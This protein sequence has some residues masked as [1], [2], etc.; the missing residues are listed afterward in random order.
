M[1]N[2]LLEL[3]W[4]TSRGMFIAP[5]QM[6]TGHLFNTVVMIWNNFMPDHMATNKFYRRYQFGE[7][8][9][10]KYLRSILVAMLLE[11]GTRSLDPNQLLILNKMGTFFGEKRWLSANS[12]SWQNHINQ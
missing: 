8:Y 6:K 12:Y 9:T 1:A 11:L 5:K 4:R 10:E 7:Y 2:D 3:R